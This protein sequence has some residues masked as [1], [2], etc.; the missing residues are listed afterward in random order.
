M[1]RLATALAASLF[2]ALILAAPATQAAAPNWTIPDGV[3]TVNVNGYH[4][5]YQETGTGTPVVLVHGS[6]S[7]YR[8]WSSQVPELAKTNRVFAL[9]LRHY[10][11][12]QW[13]G[14][15]D[16]FSVTQHAQ[17]TRMT[18]RRS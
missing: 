17:T 6:L 12:E 11:P 7:D 8:A 5:A 16:D 13:D 4:M 3:K 18:P 2:L 15:G 9:S 10:Y 14:R 1:A